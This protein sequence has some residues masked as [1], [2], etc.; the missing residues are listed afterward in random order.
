MSV[1]IVVRGGILATNGTELPVDPFAR[2][3]VSDANTMFQSTS[4]A[5]LPTVRPLQNDS[6]VSSLVGGATIAQDEFGSTV[7]MTVGGTPA[8]SAVRQSRRYVS[9]QPGKGRL[10]FISAML[11]GAEAGHPAGVVS[12]IGVFDDRNVSEK[13]F[14]DGHFFQLAGGALSVVERSSVSGAQVDTVVARDAWDGDPLDGTGPSGYSLRFD[15]MHIF[16]IDM[17]WL[18]VGDVRMGI[19]ADGKLV[20]CHTFQHKNTL[21]GSYIRT[22]KLPI[23]HEIS[24][25][26]GS[27]SAS[28]RQSCA[29]VISEGGFIPR[30]LPV[31]LGRDVTG[32]ATSTETVAVALSLRADGYAPRATIVPEGLSVVSPDNK[33]VLWRALVDTTGAGIGGAAWTNVSTTQ[34][35][36]RYS[37][38]AGITI[39]AGAVCIA[40]GIVVARSQQD[41]VFRTQQGLEGIP[42]LASTYAGVPD[43]LYITIQRL[44]TDTTYH[45][46][47]QWNEIT[48]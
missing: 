4:I 48:V 47:L 11:A 9:Y 27:A 13:R 33:A 6:Q 22:P 20:R 44:S 46:T 5:L 29:T 37:T 12:R 25:P 17:E 26:S 3:R 8:S 28:M 40:D 38:A 23:R 21:I 16:W 1:P 19:V 15:R 36:A 34:S 24:A 14:G 39:P 30:G 43:T 31:S 45:L 41:L 2:V 10:I 35:Y 32:T 7:L 42:Y 18:G